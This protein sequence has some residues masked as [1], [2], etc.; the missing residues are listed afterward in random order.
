MATLTLTNME[1][2]MLKVALVDATDRA[3]MYKIADQHSV[4]LAKVEAELLADYRRKVRGPGPK[5]HPLTGALIA[6]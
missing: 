5:A 4:L 1:L 3:K 2:T 6:G